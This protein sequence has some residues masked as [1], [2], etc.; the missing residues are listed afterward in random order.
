MKPTFILWPALL[1]VSAFPIL[2]PGS[3]RCLA[4]PPAQ[5]TAP[6]LDAGYVRMEIPQT[7]LTDQVFLAKITMKNTGS[8]AWGDGMSLRSQDPLDNTTWGTHFI[9]M[10]QGRNAK[11]GEEFTFSSYLKAPAVAGKFA[12][13]W[14]VMRNRDNEMF[15]EPT[16]REF[17]VVQKRPEE[18]VGEPPALEPSR[19]HVLSFEDFEYA[20]SFKVP[21]S[22][23]KRDSVWS[24]SGLALRKMPDGTKRLFMNY[25]VL[26]EVEI[27]ELVKLVDG[28]HAPLKVAEVKKVWGPIRL[29]KEGEQEIS[30]NAEFWW[31]GSRKLLYWSSYHGYWTGK[32][33]PLLAA[34]KLQDDGAVIHYGPWRLPESVGYFKS[35]WG[36]VTK[37]PKAFAD[38]YAGGRTLAIGFGGYYSICASASQGPALAAIA[39]PDPQKP[40]LDV[41]ELLKHPWGKGDPAPRDGD[42]FIANCS[43]GGKQPEGPARGFWTM[44]DSVKT[45][46]FIDLPAGAGQVGSPGKGGFI[47]FAYLGTGRMGYDYGHI[48][49]AG[50]ADWWY[51]YDPNDLGAVAKGEKKPWEV[52]PHSRT[53]VNYPAAAKEVGKTPPAPV[54]GACFDEEEKLLYLFKRFAVDNKYPC[55]HVYRVK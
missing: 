39:E 17:I 41:L 12:F 24:E 35:Y 32:P 15:G 21:A 34:S 25:G 3:S 55:V 45:G 22:V 8:Q 50:Y 51:I 28:E 30:A 5:A 47:A 38:Q 19:K 2:A 29:L 9:I 6:A 43:W 27:P 42:Y 52:R 23:E 37:L 48:A 31:D 33:W 46:V 10:G 14:R 4:D 36:G 54:Y 1:W 20:G 18:P 40:T 11:P 7:L 13:Q 26:F 53:K 49:S 44:D 16:A